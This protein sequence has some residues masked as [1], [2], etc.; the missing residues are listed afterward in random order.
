MGC[1]LNVFQMELDAVMDVWDLH[2]IRPSSNCVVQS[3]RPNSMYHIPALWS[4]TDCKMA[5]AQANLHFCANS[6]L[7]KVQN[8]IPCDDDVHQLCTAIMRRNN[9]VLHTDGAS[10]LLTAPPEFIYFTCSNSICCPFCKI[11]LVFAAI[12][13]YNKKAQLTQREARDS[14][15]I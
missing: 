2:K 1:I 14:L 10:Y 6:R 12:E 5:V 11:Y 13:M 15:G 8:S 7:I 9:L 4:C 3:G